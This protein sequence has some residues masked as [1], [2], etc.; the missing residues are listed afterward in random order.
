MSLKNAFRRMD[1][2]HQ[3]VV[4]NVKIIK[5]YFFGKVQKNII[6]ITFF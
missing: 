1:I 5:M 3:I 2:L 6:K 4:I